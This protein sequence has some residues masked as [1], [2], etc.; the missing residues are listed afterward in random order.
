MTPF[1]YVTVLISIVLGLGITQIV[2]GVADIIHQWNRVKIFW[3]HLLLIFLVFFLHIQEWWILYDLK[4]T[5][6]WRLPIFLFAILYPILL[7]VL[8]RILFPSEWNLPSIDMQSFYFDNYRKFFLVI[9]ILALLSISDNV[10]IQ[11]R[12]LIEQI[13]HLSLL[14]GMILIAVKKYQQ[15]WLHQLVA[16]V[17]V[18][19]MIGSFVYNWN[20]WVLK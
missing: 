11:H 16:V 7:F 5:S 8:A 1:E 6:E 9:G 14:I 20:E 3:P 15:V 19:I 12:P 10:L 18:I 2:T 4:N 13:F 17:L